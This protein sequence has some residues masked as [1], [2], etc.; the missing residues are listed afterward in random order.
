MVE[1][2]KK[3]ITGIVSL[4]LIL[5]GIV[6]AQ[7]ME[8]SYYCK[9]EDNVKECLRVSASGLTCYYLGAE[10]LT[11]GD[12]CTGGVWEPLAGYLDSSSTYEGPTNGAVKVRANGK[13]WDCE[14]QDGFVDPYSRCKSGA[15]EGY[16]GEFI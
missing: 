15:S 6:A 14:T 13:D 5:S 1:L 8:K 12:R 16:L 4:A 2:S 9:S 10:D 3:Q 11:K 7:V